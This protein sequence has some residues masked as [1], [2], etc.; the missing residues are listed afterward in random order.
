M[1]CTISFILEQA[2]V[3]CVLVDLKSVILWLLILHYFYG[4]YVTITVEP[5]ATI[6]LIF[7]QS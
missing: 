5:N 7:L 3:R 6:V 1:S 4:K 2:L